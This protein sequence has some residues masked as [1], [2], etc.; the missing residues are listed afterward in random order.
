METK[1]VVQGIL[2]T[3]SKETLAGKIGVSSMTI[4]RWAKGKFKPNLMTEKELNRIY[5]RI[6]NRRT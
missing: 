3:M 2:E 1:K 6:N 5:N 4:D